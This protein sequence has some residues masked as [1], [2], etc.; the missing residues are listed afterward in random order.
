MTKSNGPDG[1]SARMLKAIYCREH[2]PCSHKTLQHVIKSGKIPNEWK[3]A[4]VTP[5]PKHSN[6]S[7]PA[8]YRPISLL[9]IISKLLEKHILIHLL[10]HIQEQSRI[11]NSQWGFTKGKAT[12]GVLL[13][14]VQTWHQILEN[15]A[16]VCDTN[17]YMNSFF[18][19]IISIWNNFP[20]EIQSCSSVSSFKR[21]VMSYL[22][23]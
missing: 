21:S 11:S 23:V 14:A 3:L 17:A 7:D 5:I 6:K 13:T 16:D 12:T 19:H 20:H 10:K 22:S 18:P 2:Y 4:L 9:Y 8:N 1:I 15:G